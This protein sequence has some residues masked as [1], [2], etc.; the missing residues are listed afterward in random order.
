MIL[1]ILK[2]VP[3]L[4]F[5]SLVFSGTNGWAMLEGLDLSQCKTLKV[6]NNPKIEIKC[7][8][9][10][11]REKDES[12]CIVCSKSEIRVNKK[13]WAPIT[14]GF[15]PSQ[16]ILFK[17]ED[18]PVPS[19]LTPQ[20]ANYLRKLFLKLETVNVEGF[21]P[22]ENDQILQQIKNPPPLPPRLASTFYFNVSK[23]EQDG[24]YS[25]FLGKDFDPEKDQDWEV[26]ENGLKEA[27]EQ[28][29]KGVH[30]FGREEGLKN[31][32]CFMESFMSACGDQPL[33]SVDLL[34]MNLIHTDPNGNGLRILR[35]APCSK[36]LQTL[37]FSKVTLDKLHVET[38]ASRPFSLNPS[39]SFHP[40]FHCLTSL[41]FTDTPM[42]G[43]CE[44]LGRMLMSD[45]T[46]PLKHRPLE[47]LTLR[48]ADIGNSDMSDMRKGACAGLGTRRGALER[49]TLSGNKNIT[50]ASSEDL[51]KILSLA[52]SLKKET[53]VWLS[54]TGYLSKDE[55][56][57]DLLKMQEISFYGVGK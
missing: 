20:E 33:Q 50:A 3:Y 5:A 13:T 26:L 35:S 2:K 31:S 34:S 36:T 12:H 18:D 40:Y 44:P 27:K 39:F 57:F 28:G 9:D 16:V 54:E 38:I 29:L 55:V 23:D 53:K 56:L 8:H 37:Y 11:I 46:N 17:N 25:F 1:N 51:E 41:E 19:S 45:P 7:E 30:L 14:Q 24:Y 48:N 49:L 15:P 47:K 43:K 52:K 21:K 6:E 4:L 32:P 22:E 10:D 42:G